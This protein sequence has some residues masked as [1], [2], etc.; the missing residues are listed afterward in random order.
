MDLQEQL[1]KAMAQN[2]TLLMERSQLRKDLKHAR[3]KSGFFRGMVDELQTLIS[4][5]E[6][7]PPADPQHYDRPQDIV[8]ETLV[9][10][11]SDWHADEVVESHKVGGLEEFNFDVAMC[12][13][14]RLVDSIINWTQKTLANHRFRKCVILMYG[15]QVNGEIHDAVGHSAYRDMVS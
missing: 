10:H 14:E 12:R 8:D 9:V 3:L 2:A 6:A 11:W 1:E 15:D 7:L 13:A 5:L 4:P